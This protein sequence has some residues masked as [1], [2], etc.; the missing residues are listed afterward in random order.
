MSVAAESTVIRRA[1]LIDATAS[2]AMGFLLAAGATQL[3]P[4][5]GLPIALL[6]GVGVFLIPFAAFLVW[7]APRALESRGLV[8]TIVVGNVLWVLASVLVLESRRV[9]PTAL[10]TAFVVAQAL[11]VAAFAYLEYRAVVR[12]RASAVA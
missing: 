4:V 6:R 11:A 7:L 12:P 8:W 5:L 3:E 9:V 1:L 2:G 10:G